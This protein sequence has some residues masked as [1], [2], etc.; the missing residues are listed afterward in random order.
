MMKPTDI[1]YAA[2]IID[3]DGSIQIRLRKERQTYAGVITVSMCDPQPVVFLHQLFGGSLR[4]I[5]YKPPNR[6]QVQW[7]VA[8]KQAK[9]CAGVLLPFLRVKQQ[10][11]LNLVE[12]QRLNEQIRSCT[13]AQR[14]LRRGGSRW[15]GQYE[16]DSDVLLRTQQL[17]EHTKTLNLRGRARL[18]VLESP[19]MGVVVAA[20]RRA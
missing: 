20:G 5:K 16:I 11:A 1:A 19:E 7:S 8:A 6:H 4:K 3:A 15:W 14:G 2:G 18:I 10:Q 17:Y 12:L 13:T 9:L